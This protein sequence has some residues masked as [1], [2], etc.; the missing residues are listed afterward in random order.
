MKTE[1]R[2]TNLVCCSGNFDE[3][4]VKIEKMKVLIVDDSPLIIE[5]ITELLEDI[6]SITH[7]ISC[8][9][10]AHALVLLNEL[11]PDVAILDVNLPDGSGIEMLKYLKSKN[12]ETTVIMCTNQGSDH[13]RELLIKLGANFFIDKSKDFE[14]LPSLI[15]SLFCN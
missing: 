9:T 1:S 10:Y 13:Y 8:G 12:S 5:K 15:A 2:C 14:K 4:K 11:K 3:S 6:K 7:L